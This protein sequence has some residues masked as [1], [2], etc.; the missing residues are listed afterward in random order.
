MDQNVE[1]QFKNLHSVRRQ[2]GKIPFPFSFS[3]FLMCL[4]SQMEDLE[5]IQILQI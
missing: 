5:L 2:S 3:C 4:S 1:I